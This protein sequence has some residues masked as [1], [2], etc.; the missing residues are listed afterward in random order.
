MLPCC[1]MSPHLTVPPNN[2]ENQNFEKMKKISVCTIIHF[3]HCIKNQNHM[4]QVGMAVLEIWSGT[5]R[6]FC[7]FV[8]FEQKAVL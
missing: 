8:D 7:H 5:N 1:S 6:I 2:P 4:M 3:T